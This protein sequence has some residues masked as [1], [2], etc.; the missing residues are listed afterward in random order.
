MKEREKW[1][2]PKSK[3]DF[4]RIAE[5]NGKKNMGFMHERVPYNPIEM[6]L[7]KAWQFENE[8]SFGRERGI[9]QQ[10]F[11]T[12]HRLLGEHGNCLHVFSGIER[13]I[14][15][16]IIQWL[17]TN[18]GFSFLQMALRDAGYKIVD[19]PPA[20]MTNKARKIRAKYERRRDEWQTRLQTNN[21]V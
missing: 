19:I 1:V 21:H 11:C 14:V 16:T 2:R 10:L 6:A 5:R 17:G 20:E 4:E 9:L 12:P 13:C 8:R 3:E 7:S 18:V 15:A